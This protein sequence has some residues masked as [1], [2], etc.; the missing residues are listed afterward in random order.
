[1][2]C[3]AA[4]PAATAAAEADRDARLWLLRSEA[5]TAVARMVAEQRRIETAGAHVRD[6]ERLIEILRTREREGEGSRFDRLRAEQ[7]L[8]E[9]QLVETSAA[10]AFAEARGVVS[11]MLPRGMTVA[12]MTGAV[13]PRQPPPPVQML[14]TSALSARA[15]LRALQRAAERADAESDLARRARLPAPSVFGGLKHAGDEAARER[16]GVFGM[17]V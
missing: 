8:R 4:G 5:A 6:V 16:G 11:E 9:T 1:M 14:R 7:E 15:E 3:P 13:D 10:V 2:Y 17:N 12:R